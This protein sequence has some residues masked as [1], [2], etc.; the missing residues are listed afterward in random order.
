MK[1]IIIIA[2][3]VFLSIGLY[4]QDYETALG[5]RGGFSGGVTLKHFISG[6]SAVEGIVSTRWHG[7]N[8][9]GLYEIHNEAFDVEKLNWYYGGGAHI[10][11]WEGY[12]DHPWFDSGSRAIIG[13]D[14][15]IG[16]EYTFDEAPINI[17]LDWKP[18]FNLIGYTGFWGDAGGISLRYVF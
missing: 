1:K 10:G 2:S 16:I 15:I 8:V 4:A 18:A 17:G 9:T 12:D 7:M 11:I 13:I 5:L 6:S 14:L 3:A